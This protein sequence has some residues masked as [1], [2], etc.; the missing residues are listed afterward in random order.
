[1]NE[2]IL[3][4]FMSICVLF[5]VYILIRIL[6]NGRT[7]DRIGESVDR[8][9]RENN[10]ASKSIEEAKGTVDGIGEEL[11]ELSELSGRSKEIIDR[12]KRQKIDK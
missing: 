8:A 4:F 7:D 11:E 5:M 3:Y 9:T 2:K 12:I 1:M 6:H 10:V